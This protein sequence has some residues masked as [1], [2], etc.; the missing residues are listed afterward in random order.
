[1]VNQHDP[2]QLPVVNS[3]LLF[4]N[5]CKLYKAD[6]ICDVGSF[7]GAQALHFCG[8]NARVVAL[9]ANPFNAGLL[10]T[11]MRVANAGIDVFHLAAWNSDEEISFNVLNVPHA[12]SGYRRNKMSSIRSR[13]GGK[14]DSQNVTV[15]ATRLDSF[16]ASLD[17]E[18]PGSIALWIDVEGVGFEVVEGIREI[19][20]NVCVIHIEVES[21]EFWQGQHLWPDVLVLMNKFGFSPIARRRGD[22]Q[23]DVVFI[24]EIFRRIAPLATRWLIL[25]ARARCRAGDVRRRFRRF[26]GTM[27]RTR[28]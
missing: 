19:Y 4:Q 6:L 13:S 17:T 2:L 3:E 20:E 27:P 26:L 24:S 9:E 28:K 22:V 12:A 25:L 7:D 10:A 21:R 18:T 8:S 15:Q 23:V 11:N 16:V 14:F 5:L 1:M